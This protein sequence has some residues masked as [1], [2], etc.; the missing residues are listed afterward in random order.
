LPGRAKHYE[1]LIRQPSPPAEAWHGLGVALLTLGS[2]AEARE[3]HEQ[4][5]ALRPQQAGFRFEL[6]L[7]LAMEHRPRAAAREFVQC[8]RLDA[9]DGR[10][11]WAW[12]QML[13][14]KGKVR[15]ARRLLEAGLKLAPHSQLLLETLAANPMPSEAREEAPEVALFLQASKFLERK[16]GREALK[17][18]REGWAQGTRSLPLKLLDAESAWAPGHWEPYT[19]LGVC[20]LKEGHRHERRAVELLE[21]AHQLEPPMPETSLNLVLAYVKA[22]R[23]GEARALAQQVV[24]RL[25][26]EHPLYTQAPQLLEALRKV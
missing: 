6:G 1:V 12:A 24:E 13:G 26:P 19:R 10:G 3:A 8:L 22:Q 5:V 9:P 25:P 23:I 18:L 14:Q 20:L 15:S 21:T 2:V 4:A 17:L 7:A 16:R 11:Y